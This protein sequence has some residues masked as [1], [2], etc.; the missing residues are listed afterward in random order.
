MIVPG[1]V[2]ISFRQKTPLEICRLCEQAGLRAVEWGGDV[3]VPPRSKE[4]REVRKM[5]LDHGLT[6]AS[7][8]SYF[9]V[10]QPIDEL[11]ACLDTADELQTDVVR[12]WCGSKGS[13]QIGQER[14][15]V[16]EE[17]LECAEE[18]KAR[19]L[20]ISLEYHGNTLTDARESVVHLMEET[21][22][23]DALSFYWQPRWDWPEEERL[24]SLEDVRSR[25]SHLHVFT[26]R[27]EG[28]NII[29]LPLADGERM[30][31]RVLSSFPENRYALMEF[32]QDDSD[33]ALL[34][35]AKTLLD[36]IDR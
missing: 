25:L 33:E 16:V 23:A 2:S 34:R 21:R 3:H 8:G 26:W 12:I 22:A 4:A 13:Q 7:Y 30:W 14:S 18:A 9:R 1:L 31:T 35:D 15:A 27:H 28:G 20:T 36:W 6:I 19:G 32:V 24:A 10:G 11:R 5:S 17:L 29:K